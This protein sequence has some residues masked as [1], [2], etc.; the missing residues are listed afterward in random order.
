VE[1]SKSKTEKNKYNPTDER[2]YNPTDE[3]KYSSNKFYLGKVQH[4]TISRLTLNSG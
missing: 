4:K 1:Q 3:S 2:N